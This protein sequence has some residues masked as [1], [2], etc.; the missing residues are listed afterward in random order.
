MINVDLIVAGFDGISFDILKP[1]IKDKFNEKSYT[2]LQTRGGFHL[3]VDPHKVKCKINWYN[4]LTGFASCDV[5]GDNLIPIAG[6]TQGGYIPK[7]LKEEKQN[8]KE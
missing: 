4:Y 2:V 7:L 6:C 3:L 8:A 1:S 5:S